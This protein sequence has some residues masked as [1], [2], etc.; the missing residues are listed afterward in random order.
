[1]P[2]MRHDHHDPDHHDPDQHDPGHGVSGPGQDSRSR[3]NFIR[4]GSLGV[5][6]VAVA[7][8]GISS[9]GLSAA[10]DAAE[11]ADAAP[12][13]AAAPRTAGAPVALT[14]ACSG[15][16]TPEIMEGPLFKP[17]S[18]QR[19]NFITPAISGVELQLSGVVYDTACTPLADCQIEFWQCDQ[20]GDYDTAGFSLRGHQFT[21]ARGKYRL[22]TIIPRDYWGRWGRRT[23]HIHTQVQVSGGPLLVTQLYFPDDTQAYGRDFAALNAGDGSFNRACVIALT[24]KEGGGYTGTF[25]FVIKTTA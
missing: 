2:P 13:A 4:V 10:A 6:S 7:A 9:T 18:P 16:E 11:A 17:Q 19:T 25:D 8:T 12:M 1:M 14:P 24:A 5:T 22:D 15:Q 23:P 20:N 3:R 21:S